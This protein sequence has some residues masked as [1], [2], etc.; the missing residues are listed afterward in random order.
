MRGDGILIIISIN[1]SSITE[2]VARPATKRFHPSNW[3]GLEASCRPWTWWCNDATALAG[4]ATMMTKN[5]FPNHACL[6]ETDFDL[7]AFSAVGVQS[8]HST[9]AIMLFTT[10]FKTTTFCYVEPVFPIW[11]KRCV[12]HRH[13]LSIGVCHGSP[14]KTD[15]E[16]ICLIAPK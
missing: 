7:M 5:C 14:L 13:K 11:T 6:D 15:L 12:E 4:Y 1:V 16:R 8:F 3:R 9:N 2:Q 10:H